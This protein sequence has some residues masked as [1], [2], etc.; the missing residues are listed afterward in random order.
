M[1]TLIAKNLFKRFGKRIVVK[2]LSLTL[3]TGK[4]YGL[5][6]RNG[7]GKTTTFQMITGL[8]KPNSGQIYFDQTNIISWPTNERARAGIT[9]L[10]QESSVFLK[11][12]VLN[13][14]ALILRE[15]GFNSHQAKEKALSLLE[16][17]GLKRL[18]AQPAYTLSGGERRRLEI[19]RA[20]ILEPKF[21]LLDEP[22]TGIDPITI[23]ELQRIFL[24]LKNKGI[25]LL[26]SDHNVK[27]TFQI[28]NHVFIIDGGELLVEGHPQEVAH[29]PLAR[30][31]F[32]GENFKFGEERGYSSS[33][34]NN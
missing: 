12:T 15:K 3:E 33:V 19:S 10:P 8:I 16:E 14:L 26:L 9:Y 31:R 21:L 7:A 20:L 34:G 18:W 29:H 24:N 32:L 13:N 23:N 30:Q 11:T 6:G 27:D 25:G 17:L 4:I 28:A 5:L 22:F 1:S 2:N